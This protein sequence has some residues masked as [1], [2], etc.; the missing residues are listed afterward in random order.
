[1]YSAEHV[2][3]NEA[4]I[5]RLLYMLTNPVK[6]GLVERALDWPGFSTAPELLEG[7]DR[8]F[9]VFD[10]SSWHRDGKPDDQ[11]LYLKELPLVV[12]PLPC[13]K[14]LS[15]NRLV[16]HVRALVEQRE[17]QCRKRRKITGRSV[18]GVKKILA[19]DPFDV[20][21]KVDR[22]PRPLCHAGTKAR[23]MEFRESWVLF[24]AA[25]RQASERY[26]AGKRATF[27]EG[28]FPPWPRAGP[29]PVA[30]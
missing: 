19:T 25:Y 3:D 20:P 10:R 27:P 8:T 21:R 13:W 9:T 11:Q 18:L 28:S 5:D 1:M 24:T 17:D 30:A 23:W 2:L 14:H 22:S 15:G 26:R 4:M 12:T 6:D 29:I 7:V 16:A